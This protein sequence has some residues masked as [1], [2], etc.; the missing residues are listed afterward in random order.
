MQAIDN[1]VPAVGILCKDGVVIAGEKKVAS[2]LLAPPKSSEKLY[3]LDEHVSC[4][5]AGSLA[6]ELQQG[7]W[8]CTI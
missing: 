2:K 4:A 3:K 1:A 6:F 5:V 8:N 7:A